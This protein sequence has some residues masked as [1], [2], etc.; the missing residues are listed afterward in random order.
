MASSGIPPGRFQLSVNDCPSRIN[1]KIAELRRRNSRFVIDSAA[2]S[3]DSTSVIPPAKSVASEREAWADCQ[4]HQQ[5]SRQWNLEHER[6]NRQPALRRRDQI[7]RATDPDNYRWRQ[8]ENISVS[9]PEMPRTI[10]LPRQF[11]AKAGEQF[12]HSRND[13]DS[14]KDHHPERSQQQKTWDRR[15]RRGFFRRNATERR[16]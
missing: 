14:K 4:L 7:K 13:I 16:M 9:Q 15:A 5:L 6:I 10:L 3:H 12:R 11:A 2:I 8:P 1:G